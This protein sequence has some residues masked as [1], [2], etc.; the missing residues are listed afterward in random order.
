MTGRRF[1][2]STEPPELTGMIARTLRSLVRRAEDGDINALEELEAIRRAAD[3]AAR[4]A[5]RGLVEG[6]G[7]YSWGEVGRWL[8]LSR[9]GARQ[10]YGRGS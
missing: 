9:Q 7:G 10:R 8:G 5:A 3:I 1:D 4:D 2:R 6:P